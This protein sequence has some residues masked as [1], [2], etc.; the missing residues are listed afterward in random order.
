MGQPHLIHV[1]AH[2]RGQLPE[3]RHSVLDLLPCVRSSVGVKRWEID[4][5]C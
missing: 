3:R 5:E 1:C 4:A 2:V